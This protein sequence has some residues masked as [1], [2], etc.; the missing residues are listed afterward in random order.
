VKASILF[1]L[2]FVACGGGR[3]GE[4]ASMPFD[5]ISEHVGD[6]GTGDAWWWQFDATPFADAQREPRTGEYPT[7][8]GK[9]CWEDIQA[10]FHCRGRCDDQTGWC[11]RG[12]VINDVCV[13]GPSPGC[14]PP[15]VCCEVL[16]EAS[17][18]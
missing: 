4:D 7:Y 2:A 1:P 16:P 8:D 6:A 17:V 18:P 14:A 3:N 13:C 12:R 5:A 10:N 11:C 9:P 15:S